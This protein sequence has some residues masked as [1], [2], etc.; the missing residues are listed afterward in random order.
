MK[1]SVSDR[2]LLFT[3]EVV[4]LAL[5]GCVQVQQVG[6]RKSGES[7]GPPSPVIPLEPL[8]QRLS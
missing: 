2:V 4:E 1:A 8:C 5:E 6:T 3:E 7:K